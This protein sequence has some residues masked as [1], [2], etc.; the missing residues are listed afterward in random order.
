MLKKIILTI[1]LTVLLT[2]SSIYAS[3]DVSSLASNW[4]TKF[5]TKISYKYSTSKEI[6]YFKWFS[7]QL[8]NLLAVK[9]F[10]DVQIKLIDDLIKLS[11]ERVFKI[12]RTNEE[13]SEKII[14]KTNNLLSDFKYFSYNDERIFLENWIWYTYKFEQHLTFPKWT[15]IRKEDLIYNWIDSNKALVFLR[16]DK[17]LWFANT[18]TKIKLISDNIIY[19][20]PDKYNFLKEVKNDKKKIYTETDKE[21]QNLKN[22]TK[23]LTDWK[24]ES[25]KIKLI[26]NYVLE[27]IEY[28]INYTLSDPTI[29]SWIDTLSKK[30]WVCEWYTKI[31]LYMLN[32]AWINDIEVIRWFVIDAQDFPKVWHA[33]VKVRNKYFDPTF[34]DPVWQTSTRNFSQYKYYS[35]PKDLIYTNRYDYDKLPEELKTKSRDYIKSHI[36]WKTAPIVLKYKYSWYNILKPFILKLENWIKIDKKLDTTDLIKIMWSYNVDNFRFIKNWVTKTITNLKYYKVIDSNIE[37]IV[38]QMDYNFSNKY[39]FKWKLDNWSYE[40]RL[41]Y[42]VELK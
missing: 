22:I 30:I 2:P 42:D 25:E 1:L 29:F 40:Y 10:N 37:T 23:E 4:F 13:K 19:W 3:N 21:F 18:Y 41:W 5:S 36:A 27:N 28:P 6:S 11:N 24:K 9:K 12:K 35:L 17:A 20:I 14:L 15:T 26:Y 7:T 31:L 16:E 33:W 32:F 8:N 34:D 38:E 39:L